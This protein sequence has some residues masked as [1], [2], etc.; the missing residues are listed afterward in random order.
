MGGFLQEYPG[1]ILLSILLGPFILYG[2][3]RIVSSAWYRSKFDYLRRF[4]DGTDQKQ[5]R[6][7]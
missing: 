1:M 5:Q 3:V 2:V 6:K 4:T 7:E